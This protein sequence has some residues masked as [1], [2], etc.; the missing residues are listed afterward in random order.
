MLLGRSH[1]LLLFSACKLSLG[2]RLM[3][4][5]LIISLFSI[6]IWNHNKIVSLIAVGAWLG[7]L[8]L[9]IR[10]TSRILTFLS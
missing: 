6:A 7:G 8:A 2:I 3:I 4:I 1:R 9:H 10:S 5:G